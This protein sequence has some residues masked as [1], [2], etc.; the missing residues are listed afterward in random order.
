MPDIVEVHGAVAE[1]GNLPVNEFEGRLFWVQGTDP[2]L[3][4]DNGIDTWDRVSIQSGLSNPM[5][6]PRDI[7]IG[8]T[9]GAAE[10]LGS[11]DIAGMALGIK[12]V[13]G[14][15]PSLGYIMPTYTAALSDP[16]EWVFS[17]VNASGATTINEQGARGVHRGGEGTNWVRGFGRGLPGINKTVEVGLVPHVNRWDGAGFGLFIDAGP[18]VGI[19]MFWDET[20]S[21]WVMRTVT[22][23]TSSI[24]DPTVVTEYDAEWAPL[25]FFRHFTDDNVNFQF[26]YSYDAR[27]W[28]TMGVIDTTGIITGTP[29]AS[30]ML[31]RQPA[32]VTDRIGLVC[33]HYRE[34]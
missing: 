15:N 4:R 6:D 27:I 28:Q 7:I 25:V 26:Y 21:K 23:D 33:V 11:T 5:T 18:Y 31:N 3:Y 9:G 20:N 16:Q 17:N 14:A 34:I 30:Y 12:G 13:T 10:R 32:A 8:G 19:G 1:V 22:K 24:G 2:G 29:A